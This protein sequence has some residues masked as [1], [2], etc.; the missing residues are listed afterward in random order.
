MIPDFLNPVYYSP[1]KREYFKYHFEGLDGIEINYSQLHQ[2]LFVLSILNGFRGGFYLEIGASFP[3][4]LSNTYLLEEEFDWHGI[5]IEWDR[6]KV[7]RHRSR[8]KNNCF[9]VDA[10]SI[11]YAELLRSHCAPKIIDYL[12]IDVDPSPVSFRAL[13]LVLEASE[14]QFRVITFE[15]DY[16][17]QGRDVERVKSRELLSSLGYKLVVPDVA[18]DNCSFEDWWVKPELID[19]NQLE[20]MSAC[21]NK[22]CTNIHDY[23]YTK[24]RLNA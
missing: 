3:I 8:R 23:F 6:D 1:D 20:V 18:W 11:C 12:S 5:S 19:V 7:A 22:P 24:Y 10:I 15:H 16:S 21:I 4:H 9:N 14:Y 2:D 13:E 17:Y